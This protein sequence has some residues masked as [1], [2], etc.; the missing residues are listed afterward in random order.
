MFIYADNAATTKVCKTAVDAMLPYFDKIY[1]NPSSLY[2][3]GQQAK[4]AIED[5]RSRI[6]DV[7]GCS[8]KEIV[9]IV[10]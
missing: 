5:A 4:T 8:F 1:G 7:L 2:T 10:R 3:V 9:L 6:A